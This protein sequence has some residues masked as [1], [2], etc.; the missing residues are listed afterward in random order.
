MTIVF[1][2][3]SFLLGM[4]LCVQLIGA[5]YSV[6][7]LWY[8]ISR[9]YPRVIRKILLWSFI[10]IIVAIALGPPF[11]AAYLAGLG[12]NVIIYVAIFFLYEPMLSR[13]NKY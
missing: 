4:I 5:L 3:V 6:I 7:D 10:V 1:Q 12:A 9:E 2:I 11:R 13:I 8:A